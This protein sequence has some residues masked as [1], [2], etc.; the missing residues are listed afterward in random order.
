MKTEV[1]MLLLFA[2]F[3][4]LMVQT[5]CIALLKKQLK[6]ILRKA[7]GYLK[8]ILEDSESEENAYGGKAEN[9]IKNENG[10]GIPAY[11]IE[12]TEQRK[13]E[14]RNKELLLQEILGS[15]FE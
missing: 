9:L 8:Y 11:Y 2:I 7:E 10:T 5:V 6:S 1:T 3:L 12:E 13:Q 4:L 15:V 14:E